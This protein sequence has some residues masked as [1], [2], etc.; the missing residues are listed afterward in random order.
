MRFQHYA[1]DF[2]GLAALFAMIYL[3]SLFASVL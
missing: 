3:W 1:A 2:I